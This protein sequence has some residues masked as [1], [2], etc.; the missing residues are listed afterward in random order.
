MSPNSAVLPED[1]R[2]APA[3][4]RMARANPC[5]K[6]RSRA[7]TTFHQH[8]GVVPMFATP[9]SRSSRCAATFAFVIPLALA[10][11]QSESAPGEPSGQAPSAA[12]ESA[13]ETPAPE[14]TLGSE[15]SHKPLERYHPTPAD[16]AL[17]NGRRSIH[18][19]GLRRPDHRIDDRRGPAHRRLRPH[20]CPYGTHPRGRSEPGRPSRRNAARDRGP[21]LGMGGHLPRLRLPAG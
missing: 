6:N 8:P 12:P 19:G 10:S 11:C 5:I 20:P 16:G 1:A 17:G 21:G 2:L 15:N 4:K 7:R 9:M 3:G 18:Q 13:A 14:Y